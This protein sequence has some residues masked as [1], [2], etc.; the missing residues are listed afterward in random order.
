MVPKIFSVAVILVLALLAQGCV[1]YS[2]G[3][4]LPR[5]TAERIPYNGTIAITY[6]AQVVRDP[7]FTLD[8]KHSKAFP[9]K[10]KSGEQ[11]DQLI[12][13]IELVSKEN[14]VRMAQNHA[15][16]QPDIR[17]SLYVLPPSPP[18]LPG[19]YYE[20]LAGLTLDVLPVHKQSDYVLVVQVFENGKDT[21]TYRY[22]QSVNLWVQL[23]LLP[24]W[25][26]SDFNREENLAIHDLAFNFIQD[27]QKDRVAHDNR[28]H[29]GLRTESGGEVTE[30]VQ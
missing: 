24:F 30:I 19:Q 11:L 2:R 28:F 8:V 12:K 7:E 5:Y 27:F 21:K 25:F 29:A 22:S 20:F 13:A 16:D 15:L 6:E 9:L 3:L 4:T 1:I 10:H 17:F 26:S 14:G 18:S 23:F